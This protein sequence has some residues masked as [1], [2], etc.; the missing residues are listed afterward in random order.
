[1]IFQEPMTSLNPVLTIG[2]QI[3]EVLRR[4]LGM[5][6]GA[7]RERTVELLD[8]VGIP[9]PEK[10]VGEYPHQ[11]SGG[12]RQRVMIAM[13]DRLRAQAADRRRADHGARR[14]DPG[15]ACSTSCASCASAWAW[16]SC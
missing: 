16:R 6:R 15:A 7:A 3:G 10:R 9:A 1:M 8:L 14:D 11:L 4:H 2:R 12:M 13:G 5:S